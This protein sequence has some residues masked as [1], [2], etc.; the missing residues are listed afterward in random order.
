MA[1]VEV[2]DNPAEQRFEAYVDGGLAGFTAY[3]REDGAI[4]LCTPRSTTPSRAR[5]SGRRWCVR[6]STGCAPTQR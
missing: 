4:W 2:R 1:D 3:Q 5:G 6:S